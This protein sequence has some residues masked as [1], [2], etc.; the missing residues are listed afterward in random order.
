MIKK[1]GND[2]KVG[3]AHIKSSIREALL[4]TQPTAD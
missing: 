4:T 3:N 1:V 2:K